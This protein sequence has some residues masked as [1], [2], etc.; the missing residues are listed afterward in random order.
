MNRPWNPPT[1]RQRHEGFTSSPSMMCQSNK[2][3]LSVFIRQ[4]SAA[5][6]EIHQYRPH[7]HT[8]VS[9]YLMADECPKMKTRMSN[10]ET[11]AQT[12]HTLLNAC[13]YKI[14][15]S[16][17]FLGRRWRF[18]RFMSAPATCWIMVLCHPVKRS[19]KKRV[20]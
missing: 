4:S 11:R 6:L 5:P 3:K 17:F 13:S 12:L 10:R 9:V 16:W 14:C 18:Q 15:E 20:S 2:Q 8:S 19:D 1:T 7:T